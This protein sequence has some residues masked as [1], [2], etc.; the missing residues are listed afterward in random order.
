MEVCNKLNLLVEK[1]D[2]S[3][4]F[5]GGRVAREIE[6]VRDDIEDFLVKNK[7]VIEEQSK[8]MEEQK[9]AI[10]DLQQSFGALQ[11]EYTSLKDCY[12]NLEKTYAEQT[13]RFELL[14]KSLALE[15]SGNEHMEAFQK[16]ID[17]DYMQFASEESSLA[18]E[19]WAALELQRIVRRL[20]MAV[21]IPGV[22]GKNLLAIAGGFS[23]G[24]SA[25]I[26]SFVEHAEVRLATG[27]NPVTV[28][29]SY[30]SSSADVCIKLHG[31]QGGALSIN[32]V[33]YGSIS[34]EYVKGFGFDLRKIIPMISVEVPFKRDAFSNVCI[35]DT[36]G[37]N[38]GNA[39]DASVADKYSA[40][41]LVGQASSMI[42]VV[43]LDTCGTIPQTDIEFISDAG[44]TGENL[45]IVLNKADVKAQSD[46]E[47]I[48]QQVA[49]D[50]ELY[51]IEYSGICAYSSISKEKN[52]GHIGNALDDF[53]LGLNTDARLYNELES[54]VNEVFSRYE[55]AMKIEKEE[56]QLRSNT[57]REI[58]KLTLQHGGT[59][60][61]KDAQKLFK[62]LDL[63]SKIENLDAL[64][65]RC[66]DLRYKIL[67]CM[68]N[69]L[70]SI[71]ICV[72]H[73]NI[74]ESEQRSHVE[75]C[76]RDGEHTV[77]AT[78]SSQA[79]ESEPCQIEEP[80]SPVIDT[81][82]KKRRVRKH[83][84]DVQNMQESSDATTRNES[85]NGLLSVWHNIFGIAEF[86]LPKN[87]I[88]K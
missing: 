58:Q 16:L 29:P 5:R 77:Q 75:S 20:R 7:S 37:Y 84:S 32:A 2:R 1:V 48:L 76:N 38:P 15:P 13:G 42:W 73:S 45:Y 78:L 31:R 52:L 47:D 59:E 23:S 25:F 69:T 34:H 21:N 50:L 68:R 88:P 39:G 30:I 57:L 54:R 67:E 6:K 64:Q 4:V 56:L 87:K 80:V 28:I 71:G 83:E 24:K 8:K 10:E 27:I 55:C 82:K 49:D 70:E 36:P 81:S 72:P 22:A 9:F 40:S 74:S 44:I 11:G 85:V 33:E 17:I 65:R 60:F 3:I 86:D 43:G 53:I 79:D 61:F 41:K 51:G 35:V 12:V 62:K 14:N 46:I 19:A 63:A 18:D 26:N 66:A